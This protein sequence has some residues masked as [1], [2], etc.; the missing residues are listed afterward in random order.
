MSHQ[1]QLSRRLQHPWRHRCSAAALPNPLREEREEERAGGHLFYHAGDVLHGVEVGRMLLFPV[2]GSNPISHISPFGKF[3]HPHEQE[4]R[5]CSK[6]SSK[7]CASDKITQ[8]PMSTAGRTF[9]DRKRALFQQRKSTSEG[10]CTYLTA[11][12]GIT[13]L[14][15]AELLER[16]RRRSRRSPLEVQARECFNGVCA[17]ATLESQLP[18]LSVITRVFDEHLGQTEFK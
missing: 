3:S 14:H 5:R 17:N 11:E 4:R 2:A 10:S 9:P 13:V 16:R 15:G 8:S 7:L 12:L 18:K 6:G 1:P